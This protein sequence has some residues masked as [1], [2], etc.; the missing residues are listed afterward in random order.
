VAAIVR[1]RSTPISRSGLVELSGD[2]L[3]FASPSGAFLTE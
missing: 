2:A 3:F 1:V